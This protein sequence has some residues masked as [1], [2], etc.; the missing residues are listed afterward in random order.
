MNHFNILRMTKRRGLKPSQEYVI[1]GGSL[2]DFNES[3]F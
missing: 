1:I 3:E 2:E